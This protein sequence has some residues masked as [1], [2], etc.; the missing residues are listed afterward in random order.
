M[1]CTSLLQILSIEQELS[2]LQDQINDWNQKPSQKLL[3]KMS[4]NS[5]SPLKNNSININEFEEMLQGG[6]S[7]NA[8]PKE[9]IDIHEFSKMLG[10]DD[11]ANQRISLTSPSIYEKPMEGVVES[12]NGNVEQEESDHK[13]VQKDD[14]YIRHVRDK[15]IVTMKLL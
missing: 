2:S 1:L 10:E 6:N 7:S 9:H 15:R 14:I 11:E 12:N 13:A 8:Q 5:H 3:R 4:K